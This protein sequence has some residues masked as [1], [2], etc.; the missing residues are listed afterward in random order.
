MRML[1]ILSLITTV[2]TG[3]L[4]FGANAGGNI[5]LHGV[6]LLST[7][8]FLVSLVSL[9]SQGAS[10]QM[11]RVSDRMFETSGDAQKRPDRHE[12]QPRK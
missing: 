9:I 8:V 12:D 11:N 5:L 3:I 7:I 4:V 10:K 1:C 6:F 2:W